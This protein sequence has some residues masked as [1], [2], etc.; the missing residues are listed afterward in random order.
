MLDGP[1]S[2]VLALSRRLRLRSGLH[3]DCH[4]MH[5][6][7]P[8]IKGHANFNDIDAPLWRRVAR[9]SFYIS[10]FTPC[11]L[12][13][14]IILG[15]RDPKNSRV[16]LMG[17]ENYL[18]SADNNQVLFS[19]LTHYLLREAYLTGAGWKLTDGNFLAH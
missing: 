14:F 13:L 18:R 12:P 15:P 9:R 8:Q 16:P 10:I 19:G 3:G 5:A 2:T 11:S 7:R 6:T 4:A 1:M 17:S